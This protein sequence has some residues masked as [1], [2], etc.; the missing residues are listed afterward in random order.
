MVNTFH[1]AGKTPQR[2]GC[3]IT[4]GQWQNFDIKNYGSHP[5][6]KIS[7]SQSIEQQPPKE[8]EWRKKYPA[9]SCF[10]CA[11]RQSCDAGNETCCMNEFKMTK[12]LCHRRI[13]RDQWCL[14]L[15]MQKSIVCLQ[16]FLLFLLYENHIASSTVLSEFPKISPLVR[17]SKLE[18]TQRCAK[19]VGNAGD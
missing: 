7:P 4:H 3:E 9:S 18:V 1:H 5:N 16:K 8:I 15:S 2:Q 19:S 13:M 14:V 11:W 6:P 10:F 17:R 12:K